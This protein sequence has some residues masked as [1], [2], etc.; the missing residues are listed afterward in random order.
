MLCNRWSRTLEV[1]GPLE[2]H[3]AG[4]IRPRCSWKVMT[5][6]SCCTALK[7]SRCERLLMS[8]MSCV[9]PYVWSSGAKRLGLHAAESLQDVVSWRPELSMAGDC[10]LGVACGCF[11]KMA[12]GSGA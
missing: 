10:S 11:L 3:V 2:R 6:C 12:C 9:P 7:V 5:A 1:Y 4:G 8:G